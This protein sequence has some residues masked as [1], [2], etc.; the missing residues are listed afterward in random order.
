MSDL[1]K[2]MMT[3]EEAR[4]CIDSINNNLRN[5]R[6]LLLDLYEREG[7]RA[8]GY[9]NWRDCATGEFT[10]KQAHLYRELMAARVEQNI[11]PIGEKPE[12]GKIPESHL[13]PL[14]GMNPDQQR[15]VY[16]EAVNT[17][18]DGKVTARHVQETVERMSDHKRPARL[19]PKET[20]KVSV[21][22]KVAFDNMVSVIKNEKALKW[23]DTSK[24]DALK[25]V[26][27]LADIINV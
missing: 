8:L 13:R 7:W 2:V 16:Q 9:N 1:A 20:E 12:V 19:M 6:E 27:I 18:P 5:T 10:V 17:A 23:K 26:Q 25:Y 24:A 4:T 14:S 21:M 3:A 22:F 15:E 11:S